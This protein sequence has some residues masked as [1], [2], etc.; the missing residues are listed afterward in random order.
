MIFFS[1]SPKLVYKADIQLMNP[2]NTV[3]IIWNNVTVTSDKSEFIY[4]VD[5]FGCTHYISG[6]I[7]IINQSDS[8]FIK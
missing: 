3:S 4:F 5:T 8:L 2:D 1:C 7:L 6:N